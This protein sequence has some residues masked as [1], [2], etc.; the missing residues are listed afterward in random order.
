MPPVIRAMQPQ[1]KEAVLELIRSTT[2]FKAIEIEVAG[3]LVEAYHHSGRESGYHVL[4]AQADSSIAGYICYGPTPL[5]EGTWDVYW[6][7][8][9]G[10]SRRQGVA[11]KLLSAA[12]DSIRKANGR[13]LLIET[14]SL[15]QNESARH[16]YRSQGYRMVATILDFYAPN[17][18]KIIF[19]KRLR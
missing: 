6:I 19:Q 2:E 13:L 14:S 16:L 17:D 10:S 7:A 5:T 9:S 11:R 4:V 15:P 8:V 12:E 1:D 18:D 3:E